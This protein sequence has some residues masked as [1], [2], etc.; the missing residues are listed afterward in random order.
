MAS[1]NAN[2]MLRTW[3]HNKASN[4]IQSNNLVHLL[5]ALFTCGIH[6]CC[7]HVSL[8]V[9]MFQAS[10]NA[11]V[12]AFIWQTWDKATQSQ[13][14]V[15]YSPQAK[16]FISSA[17]CG[18]QNCELLCGWIRR[19]VGKCRDGETCPPCQSASYLS[20]E[21]TK[22]KSCG[23]Q[24]LELAGCRV[25]PCSGLM[26]SRNPSTTALREGK[27]PQ[28]SMNWEPLKDGLP[29]SGET[30]HICSRYDPCLGPSTLLMVLQ[31]HLC[32]RQT[33]GTGQKQWPEAKATHTLSELQLWSENRK[34]SWIFPFRFTF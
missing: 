16:L 32:G 26:L 6:L 18:V 27:G 9:R 22:N 31:V 15:D 29:A 19:L 12:C 8:S 34:S 10:W 1:P 4:S 17:K 3:Y 25:P 23:F 7:V 28:V 20:S 11:V 24:C 21:V 30:V 13:A 2:F 33:G 14:S 5:T